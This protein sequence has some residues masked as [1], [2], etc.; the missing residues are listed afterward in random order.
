MIRLDESLAELVRS[1]KVTLEVG[2]AVRRVAAGARGARRRATLRRP[3]PRGRA[4][5]CPKIDGLF[6][7]LVKRGG[8]DL[9]LARR[10]SAARAHPRRARAD[11]RGGWSTAKE[12]EDV[13]L[14]LAHAGA[15]R[16]ARRPTSISTSRT[17]TRTTAR[18]RANY[19]DEVDRARGAVFRL[20]PDRVLTL[21]ELGVPRGALARSPIDAPAS[22]SSP[23]RR[24]SGKSTT[25]AAMLDHINKT[26]ACHIL[27][28]EDPIE[29]VHEPL[30]AQITHREVGAHAPSFAA[31][32]RSAGRENADVVLVGELRSAETMK[33]ALQLASYGILVFATV[34]TNGAA[35]TI[36][37]F[38]NRVL[39]PTSSRRSAACS[40]RA[41]PASSRSSCSRTADGKARVAA[42]EILLGSRGGL[43]ADPREQDRAARATS[44]RPARRR[45]CR[46]WMAPREAGHAGPHF[47]RRRARPRGRPRDLRAGRRA[48]PPRPGRVA[49]RPARDLIDAAWRSCPAMQQR[50][51]RGVGVAWWSL[52]LVEG[53]A[54]RRRVLGDLVGAARRTVNALLVRDSR[55][56][57]AASRAPGVARDARTTEPSVPMLRGE[58]TR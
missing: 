49:E 48:R 14:E 38:V 43:R 21:A 39:R 53:D 35:A 30:R 22:C 9:H 1:Q 29:F 41:W 56:I 15:A 7:E 19:F 24:G 58:R 2:E 45:A 44:C 25:L 10:L 33:L 4:E 37:R 17:R 47:G 55:M 16:A 18:F 40:P 42:H 5:P 6:D 27:T 23:A 32:M 12:L 28:I 57:R 11:A 3:P 34:H 50:P 31:A 51:A 36:D 52:E 54:T 13:L 20:V 26:R 46:P 8:S